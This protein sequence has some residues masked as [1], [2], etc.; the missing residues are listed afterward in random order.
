MRPGCCFRLITPRRF[1][2]W[3]RMCD[4]VL[5]MWYRE[6]WWIEAILFPLI[7]GDSIFWGIVWRRNGSEKR[8]MK[9]CL[10]TMAIFGVHI[11]E[12]NRN[13]SLELSFPF[14]HV[15]RPRWEMRGFRRGL[16]E[17]LE[18]CTIQKSPKQG[19]R[20]LQDCTIFF[21]NFNQ[22][23]EQKPR[24]CTWSSKGRGIFG[25]SRKFLDS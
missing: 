14:F 16:R 1:F 7:D 11:I 5:F 17:S 8:M 20:H 24:G 13:T 19:F 3:S 12:N 2:L 9:G 25:T 22:L 10:S 15:Q 6:K 23:I 18:L 4:E 21:E